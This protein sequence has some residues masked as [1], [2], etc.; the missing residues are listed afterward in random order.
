[1][2]AFQPIAV[3]RWIFTHQYKYIHPTKRPPIRYLFIHLLFLLSGMK[4]CALSDFCLA[5]ANASSG[6]FVKTIIVPNFRAYLYSILDGSEVV[7]DK[8]LKLFHKY[9][10]RKQF[11]LKKLLTNKCNEYILIPTP[12]YAHRVLNNILN[13]ARVPEKVHFRVQVAYCIATNLIST[14]FNSIGP[15]MLD[16]KNRLFEATPTQA[17]PPLPSI[18]VALLQLFA[19]VIASHF[20]RVMTAF[21]P[22]PMSFNEF[23]LKLVRDMNRHRRPTTITTTTTES[24][25]ENINSINNRANEVRTMIL[26]YYFGSVDS[27]GR[28]FAEAD[29]KILP[30]AIEWIGRDATGYS[31]MFHLVRGHHVLLLSRK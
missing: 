19:D 8:V 16:A 23:R 14:I 11:N 26:K 20:D 31:A 10:L 30:S 17:N 25:Q 2:N 5:M 24:S 15:T 3:A 1:M 22:I 27:V 6:Y 28:V 21:P 9:A 12:M 29:V 7:T 4:P 13:S 18:P